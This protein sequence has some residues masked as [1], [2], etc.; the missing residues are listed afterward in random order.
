VPLLSLGTLHLLALPGE[1]LP[2]SSVGR[3]AV[4]IAYPEPHGPYTYPAL[5]G[6][7]A[8]LPAGHQLLEIGLANDELGYFVPA[9]DWLTASHPN[10]YCESVAFGREGET[11]LRAGVE[12]LLRRIA[13]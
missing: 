9:A 4:T 10:Y 13:P 12:A 6:W 1:V 7:R 3:E 8:A 5:T 11:R 2:E